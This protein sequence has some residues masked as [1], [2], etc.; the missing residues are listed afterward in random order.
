MRYIFA[1]ALIVAGSALAQ[2]E[3]TGVDVD[4]VTLT[5]DEVERYNEATSER[6]NQLKAT[7]S[8][9]ENVVRWI[10]QT[11][12]A[13]VQNQ[14][15]RTRVLQMRS[16]LITLGKR[17]LAKLSSE[18]VTGVQI[19]TQTLT[20]AR[21]AAQIELSRLSEALAS[22]QAETDPSPDG[23]AELQARVDAQQAELDAAQAALDAWI[24]A[25]P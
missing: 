19:R 2:S 22:L 25:N 9:V 7:K 5:A 24:A 16:D 18:P 23:I 20:A 13:V 12:P 15:E 14:T 3:M 8:F 1:V 17:V 11:A 6:A 10:D 4:G 21:D